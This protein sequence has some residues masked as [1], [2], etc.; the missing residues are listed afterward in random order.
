MK[1]IIDIPE[2]VYKFLNV[3]QPSNFDYERMLANSTPLTEVI[4]DIK[5]EIIRYSD[6]HC[7]NGYILRESV[8][9]IIDKHIGK[10][11]K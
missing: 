1:L 7:N 5:A 6:V 2:E 10:E 8:I 11:Q 9:E 4:E 3:Y